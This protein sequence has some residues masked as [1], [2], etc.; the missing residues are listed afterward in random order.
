[1]QNHRL[2]CTQHLATCNSENQRIANISCSS[3]HG[4]SDWLFLYKENYFIY[5]KNGK[6]KVL[7]TTFGLASDLLKPG[8]ATRDVYLVRRDLE[9]SLEII[10]VL[11]YLEF[12]N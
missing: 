7:T 5:W 1:M 8:V 2:I 11:R 6:V 12:V 4:D 3:C 9:N 10:F